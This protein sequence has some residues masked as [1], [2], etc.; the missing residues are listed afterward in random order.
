MIDL[1]AEFAYTLRG[2]S[3]RPANWQEARMVYSKDIRAHYWKKKGDYTTYKINV[4]QAHYYGQMERCAYCRTR[5]RAEGYWE[6]LDHVVAQTDKGNWIYF[7]K[8]LVV[9]CA[10]CNR[11]KNAEPTLS[12][13]HRRHF[14]LYSKAFNIFNPHFDEWSD[15]FEVQKGIFIKGIPGTKGPNTYKYCK[16][17]RTDVIVHCVD[18]QRIWQNDETYK[19]LTHRLREVDLDSIEAEGIMGAINE[20]AR[21]KKRRK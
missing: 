4:R 13:V 11:L 10:P 2:Y 17:F 8:N 16:L 19:S 12:N 21:R 5:L 15:H 18:E 6:D 14:P 3:H 20:I 9:T 7:P 1:N